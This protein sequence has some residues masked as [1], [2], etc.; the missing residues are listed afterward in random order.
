M[1]DGLDDTQRSF[2]GL[3]FENRFLREKGK[4]F[5]TFFARVMSHGYTGDF[6]VELIGSQFDPS[7]YAEV[8][9]SSLEFFERVL[10]PA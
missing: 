10:T 1:R 9:S 6:D 5:E 7:Q 3:K 4:A 8:L 2:C